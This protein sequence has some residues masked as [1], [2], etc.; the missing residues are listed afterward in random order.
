MPTFRGQ[1]VNPLLSQ[2]KPWFL[3]GV[4]YWG[5]GGGILFIVFACAT[6]IYI[7]Q[8]VFLLEGFVCT[9][10]FLAIF[11]PAKPAKCLS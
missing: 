4:L 1:R 7:I 5:L 6:L 11:G 8:D 2:S 3:G 9:F 10:L